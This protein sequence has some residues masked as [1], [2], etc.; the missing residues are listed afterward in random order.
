MLRRLRAL[1]TLVRGFRTEPKKALFALFLYSLFT[2]ESTQAL[3]HDVANLPPAE[4]PVARSLGPASQGPLH[5]NVAGASSAASG[6]GL[7]PA[8]R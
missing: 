1:K 7:R 3:G 2:Y 6:P 8:N 5:L 4:G